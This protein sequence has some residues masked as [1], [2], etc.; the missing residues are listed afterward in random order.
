MTRPS[1]SIPMQK[2]TQL[3]IHFRTFSTL[4]PSR[5]LRPLPYLVTESFSKVRCTS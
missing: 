1:D 4:N 2:M 5:S 3:A